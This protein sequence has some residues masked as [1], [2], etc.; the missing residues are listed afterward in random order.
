MIRTLICKDP[1]F[2]YDIDN[3]IRAANLRGVG[4]NDMKCYA[5]ESAETDDN[6]NADTSIT[7]DYDAASGEHLFKSDGLSAT[8]QRSKETNVYVLSMRDNDGNEVES[9]HETLESAMLHVRA[10]A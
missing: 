7:W 9:E 4:V 10:F 6:L 8:V 1:E 5:A 3:A 2:Q